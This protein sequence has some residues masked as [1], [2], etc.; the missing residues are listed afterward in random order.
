M[1]FHFVIGSKDADIAYW[2]AHLT[3]GCFSHYVTAILNAEVKKKIAVLPVPDEP[4]LL[5]HTQHATIYFT[6]KQIEEL[7]AR[8]KRGKKGNYVKK[9]IRKHL[10]VN[11]RKMS[12][13][14]QNV[15]GLEET[16]NEIKNDEETFD[17]KKADKVVKTAGNPAAEKRDS[18]DNSA[19]DFRERMMR[20]TRR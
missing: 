17:N 4:G 16:V 2:M 14:K 13:K 7:L 8:A 15:D 18:S 1:K 20:M 11:Y 9:I 5:E 10:D 19:N 12:L 6:S 3:K